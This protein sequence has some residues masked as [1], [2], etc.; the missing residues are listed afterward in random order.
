MGSLFC[1]GIAERFPDADGY[2][3]EFEALNRDRRK[4]VAELS[5]LIWNGAVIVGTKHRLVGL[6]STGLVVS[7]VTLAAAAVLSRLP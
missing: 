1:L 7:V 2:T 3:R 6:A 5:G 4:L